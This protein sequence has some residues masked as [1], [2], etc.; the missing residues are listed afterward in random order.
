MIPTLLDSTIID[1]LNVAVGDSM[2]VF[3]PA[4]DAHMINIDN[5][6]SAGGA[7]SNIRFFISIL[8][9]LV[10]VLLAAFIPLFINALKN[11]ANSVGNIG[12][13]F[14][15]MKK[16]EESITKQS[17]NLRTHSNNLEKYHTGE[18]VLSAA[19]AY[20]WSINTP[21][22]KVIDAAGSVWKDSQNAIKSI[23]KVRNVTISIDK[24]FD[25]AR[26]MTTKYHE[27]LRSYQRI[28]GDNSKAI[29][30]IIA[31]AERSD[32]NSASPPLLIDER[33][34]DIRKNFNKNLN[35]L[36]PDVAQSLKLQLIYNDWIVPLKEYCSTRANELASDLQ[37]PLANCKDAYLNM[38]NLATEYSK[39][40][41]LDA[42]FLAEEAAKLKTEKNILRDTPFR[43]SLVARLN[44][45]R[46]VHNWKQIIRA[47]ETI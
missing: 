26:D 21:W 17:K 20:S 9:P 36:P 47:E 31:R 12:V 18:L 41:D 25:K 7:T 14:L 45:G 30:G 16:L 33:F 2:L 34:K 37:D 8:V 46:A 24:V 42:T 11:Y 1:S 6:S 27:E 40:F 43:R 4:A 29:A 28:F 44:R 15:T 39:G 38:L 10:A 32:H 22:Q 13:L 35:D 3:S 19:L 23:V 5:S